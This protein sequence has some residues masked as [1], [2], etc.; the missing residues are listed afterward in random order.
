MGE[1][2]SFLAKFAMNDRRRWG[3]IAVLALEAVSVAALVGSVQMGSAK[4]REP[5]EVRG[6]VS[7]EVLAPISLRF[8]SPDSNAPSGQS[9]F[10]PYS[11]IP[12]GA[13]SGAELRNAVANDAAVRIHY[14]D[15]AASN[16]RVERLEKTQAFYVSYRAGN[17]IFWTKKPLTIPAGETVLTDGAHMARTRC[18]NRLSLAPVGPTAPPGKP[19]PTPAAMEIP[20]GGILLA[21]TAVPSELPLTPAP[22]ISIPASAAVPPT[23]GPGI[24][25]PV[26]PFFPVGPGGGGTSPGTSTPGSPPSP[27]PPGPPSAPPAPPVATPEPS[28]LGLMAVGLGFVLL[29]K[30]SR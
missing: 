1:D 23:A 13:H 3:A 22:L 4:V 21:S 24:Y 20:D 8:D 28:A 26:I 15:F 30:K 14:A 16:A 9:A 12:G 10:Y 19:E 25:L 5:E 2:P 27:P 6:T 29:L 11:V 7:S 17:E 18:G